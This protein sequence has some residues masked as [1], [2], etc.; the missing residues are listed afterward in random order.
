MKIEQ[1]TWLFIDEAY[2]GVFVFDALER[3]QCARILTE[4]RA[5]PVPKDGP[6]SMNKYGS[7]LRGKLLVEASDLQ[8]RFV[9]PLV[10]ENFPDIDKLN[11]RPYAFVVDY[12]MKRQ[13]KLDSH[14]DSSTVTLNICLG[15]EFTGGDLIMH[16]G[17]R[18]Y[19]I[20]HKIGQAI[21]H[22]GGYVH[23]AEPLKS[24]WRSNLILWCSERK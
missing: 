16:H 8:R 21:V 7:V 5:R 23:R 4:V 1:R 15:G 2:P 12:D 17:Q 6:N 19:R 20:Q 24:G 11:P 22:R 10:E 18:R 3:W 14:F 9:K 13:R